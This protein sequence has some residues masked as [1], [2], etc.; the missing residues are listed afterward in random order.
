MLYDSF[1]QEHLDSAI[2]QIAR[3]VALARGKVRLA[4]APY[5]PPTALPPIR[6]LFRPLSEWNPAPRPGLSV[7]EFERRKAMRELEMA[8]TNR[9]IAL[10]RHRFE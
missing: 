8:L 1:K 10:H 9:S 7:T 5:E 2:S 4:P 6:P 3:L